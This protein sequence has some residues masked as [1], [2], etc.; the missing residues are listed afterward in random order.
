MDKTLRTFIEESLSCLL[1]VEKLING[2]DEQLTPSQLSE[3]SRRYR[4]I[5]RGTEFFGIDQLE[6]IARRTERLASNLSHHPNLMDKNAL[7]VLQYTTRAV[8]TML[9]EVGRREVSVIDGELLQRLT[10]LNESVRTDT[11]SERVKAML[12]EEPLWD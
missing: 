5:Q 11:Y 8:Q 7:A 1:Q 4:A 3:I 2:T 10:L 6:E 9:L 12:E